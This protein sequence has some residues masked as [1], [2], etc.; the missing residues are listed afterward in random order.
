[1]SSMEIPEW[2]RNLVC[3]HEGSHLRFI[4]TK[5]LTISDLDLQDQKRLLIPSPYVE[6]YL[7]PM[8]SDPEKA[9]ANLLHPTASRNMP[10]TSRVRGRKHGGLDV[11]VHARNGFRCYLK[12]TRWDSTGSTVINGTDYNLLL[13]Q[14][15][16][17]KNDEVELWGFRK[18]REGKLCFVL[19]KKTQ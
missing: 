16:L 12:L 6:D 13:C 9:A 2:V 8:L 5:S 19:G 11:D 15:S 3:K 17:Q 18:G 7:I 10:G 4:M 1:M 14:S